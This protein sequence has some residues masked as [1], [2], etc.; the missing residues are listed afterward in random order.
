MG[1]W[2]MTTLGLGLRGALLAGASMLAFAPVAEAQQKFQCARKGGDFVFAQEAK[3]NSLDMHTS[4]T[5]STRNV[6]MNMFES[7]MTRDDNMKP[8][9]ELAENW[10]AGM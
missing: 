7:V 4:S 6:A 9:P 1:D 8:I 3:A 5:I 2:D 10:C